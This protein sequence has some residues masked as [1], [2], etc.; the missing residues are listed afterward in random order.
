MVR[1]WGDLRGSFGLERLKEVHDRALEISAGVVGDPVRVENHGTLSDFGK[2]ISERKN[3]IFYEGYTR[4]HTVFKEEYPITEGNLSGIGMMIRI[5]DNISLF[6]ANMNDTVNI[7]DSA[8]L[9][10]EE[11]D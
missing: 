9:N 8:F 7:F 5:S 6:Q 10:G 1:E 4:L 11:G 3:Y 2:Q